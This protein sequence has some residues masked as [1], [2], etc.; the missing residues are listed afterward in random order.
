MSTFL[1]SVSCCW[2]LVGYNTGYSQDDGQNG[3]SRELSAYVC[4]SIIIIVNRPFINSS[5]FFSFFA[6]SSQRACDEEEAAGDER[7]RQKNRGH[8]G[9]R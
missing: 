8:G 2:R 7:R 6:S 5:S 3:G 1:L 4:R 9:E